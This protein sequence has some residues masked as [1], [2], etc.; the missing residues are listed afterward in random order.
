LSNEPLE[1][2]WRG[3]RGL[4]TDVVARHMPDCKNREAY[5]CGS[6]GM[7]NACIKVLRN[8]GMPEKN[9]YFD[10]FA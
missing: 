3:E 2:N 10:K 8:N 1:S 5:L 4:I 6:P 9:I 7:I